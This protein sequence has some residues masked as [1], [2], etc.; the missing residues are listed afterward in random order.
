MKKRYTNIFTI[1]TPSQMM[2]AM[3]FIHHFS[4]QKEHNVVIITCNS[5]N[6]DKLKKLAVLLPSF[7]MFFF[8]LS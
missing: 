3:E 6:F 1:S 2:N 4:I 8:P 5:K 7:S